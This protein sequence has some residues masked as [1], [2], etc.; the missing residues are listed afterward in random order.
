MKKP[1]FDCC[2]LFGCEFKA[3]D[4]TT[5][6]PA[7]VTTTSFNDKGVVK[8]SPDGNK[9]IYGDNLV[10]VA[11]L[12]ERYARALCEAYDRKIAGENGAA[13]KLAPGKEDTM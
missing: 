7:K 12:A 13:E 4:G 5:F 2:F 9:E 1:K 8:T 10:A 3:K 6:Q 11:P